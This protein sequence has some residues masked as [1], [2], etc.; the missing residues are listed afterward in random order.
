MGSISQAEKLQCDNTLTDEL[1][2]E[3][4]EWFF[5]NSLF[6]KNSCPQT[7]N[8]YLLFQMMSIQQIKLKED[9]QTNLTLKTRITNISTKGWT[10]YSNAMGQDKRKLLFM[11]ADQSDHCKCFAYDT[12]WQND[13]KEGHCVILRNI[14]YRDNVF[15]MTPQTSVLR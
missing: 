7:N 9:A 5:I 12:K 14:A 8:K 6:Y 4:P 2:L 13:V 1:L 15:H 10:T 11:I 3:L